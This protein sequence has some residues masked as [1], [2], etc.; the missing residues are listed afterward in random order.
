[1]SD[2]ELPKVCPVC[3]YDKLLEAPYD[4]FGYPSYQICN[5]CGFEYG[6][7]DESEQHTFDSYR[8][9]W[10]EQGFVFSSKEFQ[11]EIWDKQKLEAQ[12]KNIEGLPYKP[13]IH[14]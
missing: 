4:E 5:C 11:P 6:F 12:L 7:D 14:E 3:G 13:R 9:E 1:M 8:A 10:I 2:S